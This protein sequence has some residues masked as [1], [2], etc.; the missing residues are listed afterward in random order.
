M[1]DKLNRVSTLPATS[2]RVAE[3]GLRTR[4]ILK[5]SKPNLPLVTVIT[6]V[7]NG[8]SH[9]ENTI[10]SILQ[11]DYPNFEYLV[12]DGGSTDGTV[13][14]LERYSGEI[15]YWIS[16]KDR[17]ISDAFN[18]GIILS[19][20]AYLNFQGDGDG[21]TSKDSISKIMR[22]SL[23]AETLLLSGRIRRITENGLELYQS[24]KIR[25]SKESLLFKLSI[26]H[27][28]LFTHINFFERYGLFD[29][30]LKFA[31][32]YEH[33]L[34]AYR[35]FPKVHVIHDIIANWR[36]D[37]VGQGRHLEVFL[38]YDQIKRKNNVANPVVLKMIHAWTLLKYM[39]KVF[40]R[41]I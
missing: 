6:A 5:T 23:S 8:I 27:Q 15:D 20:G 29:L 31:M 11:Q 37:G 9:L 28:G 21:F 10:Q 16:E 39:L 35:N 36:A 24:P 26:P 30:S 22:N 13:S 38:E 7:F 12:I 17:G 34:R 4:G 18:K 32:D 2:Q 41:R 40:L 3:G 1:N 14:I 33:L 25:F 19:A